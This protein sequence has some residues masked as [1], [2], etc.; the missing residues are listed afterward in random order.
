MIRYT[1]SSSFYCRIAFMRAKCL[2]VACINPAILLFD[3]IGVILTQDDVWFTTFRP[4]N[5]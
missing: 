4:F 3:N 5:I 2:Y 1:P